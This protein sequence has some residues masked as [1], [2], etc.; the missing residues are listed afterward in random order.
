MLGLAAAREGLD[1]DHAAATAR[2]WPRQ[3]ARLVERGF[4]RLGLFCGRRHGEQLARV[5]N[6]FGAATA[7]EQPIVADAMEAFRQ[8]MD[9]EAPNELAGL[10]CF[11]LEIAR[12]YG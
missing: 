1:D 9:Q 10:G 5:R 11:S 7:G 4:G 3:D 6:V 12:W 2:A 8:H